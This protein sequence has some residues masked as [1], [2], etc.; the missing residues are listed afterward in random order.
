MASSIAILIVGFLYIG[1]ITLWLITEATPREPIGDPYLAV[2]EVLTIVSALALVGVVIAIWCFADAAH[3]LPAL[4][5]LAIGIL[6]AG[7]TMAVHFVQ[8]TAIRQ[9]WRV[10]RL[11]DY[12]LV[13]PSPLFALEYFVW[14]I[15]VGFTLLC[16]SFAIAGGSSAEPAR[17]ALLIGGVLCLAGVAGPLSGQ[18]F[19]Q[20]VAV[21]G[22]AVVLPIAGALT[23]RMFRAALPAAA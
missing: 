23:A 14:D 13:W 15:L 12:R 3:R 6:A 18:M 19:L 4:T 1:I 17:R 21:L 11:V 10:G 8:L 7:V 22:Y 16:M 5:A 9:L 20:N 2:M